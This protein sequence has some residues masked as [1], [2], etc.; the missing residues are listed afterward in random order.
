MCPAVV[1]GRVV[2]GMAV[3]QRMEAM[4]TSSGRPKAKVVIADCGQVSSRNQA[5]SD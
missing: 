4:G 3:V 1:F 5:W 2:E